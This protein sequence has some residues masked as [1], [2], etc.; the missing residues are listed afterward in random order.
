MKNSKLKMQKG[1]NGAD[2]SSSLFAFL[3]LN[4][5]LKFCRVAG[6]QGGDARAQAAL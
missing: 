2:L 3:I 6:A 5:S 4:F 1:R